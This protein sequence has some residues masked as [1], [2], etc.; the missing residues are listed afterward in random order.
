M[1]SYLRDLDLAGGL[2]ELPDLS[3]S[4]VLSQSPQNLSDLFNLQTKCMN[5]DFMVID[6]QILA[7]GRLRKICV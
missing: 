2:D 4:G 5:E 7:K 3:F 1:V 6:L